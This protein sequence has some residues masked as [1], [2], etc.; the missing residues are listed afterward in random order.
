M[1]S[2]GEGFTNWKT[3][4]SYN[5]KILQAFWFIRDTTE[6]SSR[7]RPNFAG[8]SG[9]TTK[10]KIHS[11]HGWLWHGLTK[12]ETSS[13]LQLL[14]WSSVPFSNFLM[15]ST[16]LYCTPSPHVLE[17]W[18]KTQKMEIRPRQLKCIAIFFPA[19]CSGQSNL[20]LYDE[21]CVCRVFLVR[22]DILDYANRPRWEI[23][24]L[25]YVSCFRSLWAV[26]KNKTSLVTNQGHPCSQ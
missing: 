9:E 24:I 15:H 16:C 17:H 21:A 26:G 8:H 10:M 7:N 19:L 6:G 18:W 3:V 5:V 2:V 22:S 12:S 25:I 13:I 20:S 11:P 14:S 4:E 1:I 23:W